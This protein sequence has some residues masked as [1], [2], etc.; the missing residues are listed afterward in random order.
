[1]KK[2]SIMILKF[3][4]T[5]SRKHWKIFKEKS[6]LKGEIILKIL[7]LEWYIVYVGDNKEYIVAIWSQFFFFFKKKKSYSKKKY[8]FLT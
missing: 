8:H 4:V 2:K 6:K 7:I 5:V 3:F 1:M